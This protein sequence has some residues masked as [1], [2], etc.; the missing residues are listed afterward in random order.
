[1]AV[2]NSDAL[3]VVAQLNKKYGANTVVAANNV[4]ATQRVTTG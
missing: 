3:K 4:V 2:I 1:M